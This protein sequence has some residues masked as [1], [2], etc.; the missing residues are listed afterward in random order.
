MF[1]QWR[2]ALEKRMI[3]NWQTAY[4]YLSVQLM[5]LAGITLFAWTAY[6][7]LIRE[8]IP[9]RYLHLFLGLVLLAGII[10]RVMKKADKPEGQSQ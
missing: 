6:P 8:I 7:D 2:W 4:K 3:A 10:G 1:N 5:A 9:P